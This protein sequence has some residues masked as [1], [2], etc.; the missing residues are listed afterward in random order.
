MGDRGQNRG[1]RTVGDRTERRCRL[2]EDIEERRTVGD[3]TG[4]RV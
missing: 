4:R 3:R 2:L 1:E